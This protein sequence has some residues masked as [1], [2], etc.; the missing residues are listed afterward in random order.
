[1]PYQSGS[2]TAYLAGPTPP[3]PR[4]RRGALR[5]VLAVL[6]AVVLGGTAVLWYRA[7]A[8]DDGA[9]PAE[10]G[11]TTNATVPGPVG[12]LPTAPAPASSADPRFVKVGEC[13]RNTGPVGGKPKLLIADCTP[14]TYEVLRRFDGETSGEKDAETKCGAVAGYTDWF[15]FDSE[16][17]SLDF[18]LCLRKR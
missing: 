2:P 6:A 9:S 13:V 1:M 14:Q 3:R 18:V 4:R 17:D 16:L 5:T 11:P 8:M 12:A 7:G 10:A 15:F